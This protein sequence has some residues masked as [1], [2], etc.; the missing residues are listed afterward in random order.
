MPVISRIVCGGDVKLPCYNQV[1]GL[2]NNRHLLTRTANVYGTSHHLT[3]T[4]VYRSLMARHLR[5]SDTG[6]SKESVSKTDARLTGEAGWKKTG[7]KWV[8]VDGGHGT[9]LL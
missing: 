3:V 4:V 1:R 9:D 2:R 6:A 5:Y 7:D 8:V